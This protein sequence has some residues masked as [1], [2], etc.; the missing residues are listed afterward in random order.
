MNMC[1]LLSCGC[2]PFSVLFLGTS[3]FPGRMSHPESQTP[4]VFL[5]LGKRPECAPIAAVRKTSQ[6]LETGKKRLNKCEKMPRHPGF[7]GSIAL[8]LSVF[9]NS[10]V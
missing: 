5:L 6:V 4:M 7:S 8:S 10:T 9:P 2:K 3:H 1:R